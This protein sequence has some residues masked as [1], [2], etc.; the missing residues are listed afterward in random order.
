MRSQIRSHDN[1][2][3]T[4]AACHRRHLTGVVQESR[5]ARASRRDLHVA[6]KASNKSTPPPE[7]TEDNSQGFVRDL[8]DK[9][10]VSLGPISLSFGDDFSTPTKPT[11][12]NKKKKPEEKKSSDGILKDV[13]DAAG[14]S[15]GPISLTFGDDFAEGKK[16]K[17]MESG[18][19]EEGEWSA[20]ESIASMTNA[21]WQEKYE[22]DG[23]VDLWVEEEF[24]A[25]S[26]LVG[27]RDVHNGGVYGF[28]TGEGPSGGKVASHNVRIYNKYADQVVEV[29]V[30][31]DRYVMWEAED[32]GLQ[33]PYACRMG[34]CT[35][36]A[37]KIK[38]GEMFQPQALGISQ[39]L[40]EQGY[41]LMCVGYPRSDLV[42]ETVNEDEVYDVQFGETFAEKALN[43]YAASIDRDDFAMELA[44]MDE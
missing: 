37:V 36:C 34:C 16:S 15:L 32:N 26:R 18:D 13:A 30:P 7:T 3:P 39:E 19:E 33:L 41:A 23:C 44:E 9:A 10:G 27:G 24:N 25:G 8:A 40:K 2:R 20:G 21:E 14:V 4:S 22:K 43:K 38:E 42:L 1:C 17:L 28:Q 6:M 12:D 31:E 29:E 35:A 5:N 11:S